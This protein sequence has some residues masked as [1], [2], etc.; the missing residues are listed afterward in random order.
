ML[1]QWTAVV[2]AVCIQGSMAMIIGIASYIVIIKTVAK[3]VL[4]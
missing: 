4:E 2:L 1:L 3:I